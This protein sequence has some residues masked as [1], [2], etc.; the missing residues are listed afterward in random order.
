MY[1]CTFLVFLNVFFSV[2]CVE[3]IPGWLQKLFTGSVNSFSFGKL[4]WVWTNMSSSGWT[5]DLFSC[6][7]TVKHVTCRGTQKQLVQVCS[8]SSPQSKDK[9]L[10][11]PEYIHLN[12]RIRGRLSATWRVL[13]QLGMAPPPRDPRGKA[14]PANGCG[15]RHFVTLFH[16]TAFNYEVLLWPFP[17]YLQ[18]TSHKTNVPTFKKVSLHCRPSLLW[19]KGSVT[20]SALRT[21]GFYNR[22]TQGCTKAKSLLLSLCLTQTGG[23]SVQR[24]YS[25]TDTTHVWSWCVHRQLHVRT[26]VPWRQSL[27][28]DQFM[29][30][31][32]SSKFK[33]YSTARHLI[34]NSM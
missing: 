19:R 5:S 13:R 1:F 28:T 9:P 10:W 30:N 31:L 20:P 3:F 29:W 17:V 21:C 16:S 11:L 2:T 4:L 33:C 27:N 26:N 7:K 34:T 14:G 32:C 8:G 12:L 6:W 23:C 24:D 18:T 22:I 25:V 15:Y